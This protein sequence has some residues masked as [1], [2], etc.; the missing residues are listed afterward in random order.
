MGETPGTMQF[1]A[2]ILASPVDRPVVMETTA[3]GAAYL[4]GLAA[5]VCPDPAGFAGTWKR[6][7][8]SVHL[9][10]VA[11][12]GLF[13]ILVIGLGWQQVLLVH[14]PVMVMASILGVWLFSLQHRFETARWTGLTWDPMQS[15]VAVLLRHNPELPV[16]RLPVSWRLPAS[17][18]PVVAPALPLPIGG[19]VG[20]Y[21]SARLFRVRGA[22]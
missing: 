9:T 21:R 10:N 18:A 11:L 16:H 6:E 17:A 4:A 2:D 7:R 1:V 22:G 5:G 13:A 15:A 20:C 14:L 3:L 19:R 8:R 12:A